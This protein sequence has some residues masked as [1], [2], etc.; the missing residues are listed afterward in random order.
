MP[1]LVITAYEANIPP[2]LARRIGLRGVVT[3]PNTIEVLARAVRGALA[4]TA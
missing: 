4:G 2:D 1:I 3:K